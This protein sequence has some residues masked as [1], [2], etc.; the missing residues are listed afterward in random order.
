[1]LFYTILGYFMFYLAISSTLHLNKTKMSMHE[2][3]Y[4]GHINHTIDARIFSDIE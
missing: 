3:S 1:M 2:N 4:I